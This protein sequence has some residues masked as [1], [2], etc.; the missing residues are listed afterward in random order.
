MESIT[1]DGWYLE[2]I[3]ERVDRR[4]REIEKLRGHLSE[5]AQTDIIG[6]GNMFCIRVDV[7]LRDKRKRTDQ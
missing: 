6:I 3:I 5:D 1:P 2:A 7:V 4:L